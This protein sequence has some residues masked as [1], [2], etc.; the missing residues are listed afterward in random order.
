MTQSRNTTVEVW[1][2]QVVKYRHG[3]MNNRQV[4]VVRFS[5]PKQVGPT[6]QMAEGDHLEIGRSTKDVTDGHRRLDVPDAHGGLSRHSV[7]IAETVDATIVQTK[8][9]GGC[10]IQWWGHATG[11]ALRMNER[12]SVTR[13]VTGFRIDCAGPLER[14]QTVS[15]EQ[16]VW[17]LVHPGRTHRLSPTST[18]HLAR[19]KSGYTI[20]DTTDDGY[21]LPN[22]MPGTKSHEESQVAIPIIARYFS[23][24]L[25]WPPRFE[26]LTVRPGLKVARERRAVLLFRQGLSQDGH[27]VDADAMGTIPV[28]FLQWIVANDMLPFRTYRRDSSLGLLN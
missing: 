18:T 14:G 11:R 6:I 15:H 28:S 1:T 21:G 12:Y 17:I 22:L 10:H 4:P 5:P 19:E 26:P 7:S 3:G 27:H 2:S 9:R 23:D 24:L 13:D 8:Q 20:E 25:E 16:A